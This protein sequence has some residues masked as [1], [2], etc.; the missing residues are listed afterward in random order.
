MG[1]SFN[2]ASLLNGNGISVSQIVQEL[3]SPQTSAINA[4]QNQQTDL[5]TNAGLLQGFNNNLTSLA[6]TVLDL[7]NPLGPLTAQSAS[8][9]DTGIL[10]ATALA[11]APAGSHR[12]VVS[13][14]AT[15]ATLY[16]DPVTNAGTSLLA[17]G[18]ITADITLQIGGASGTTHD[19]AISQGTNDTLTSLASFINSQQWGVTANVVTDANGSRLALYS[20]A[21]GAPGA[22]AIT[23]NTSVLSFNTPVGGTNASLTIDGVP[24]SSA[25]NAV[26][27]AISGVTLNLQSGDAQT[28]V[29]LTIGP[30]TDQATSAINSFVSAYN[31]LVNNLSSQFTL[32]PTSNTEGPLAADSFL[33]TLQSHLLNDVSYATGNSGLVNLASLGIDLNNDGTLTVN[34]TATET[35]P[36]LASVLASNPA[37]VQTFFQNATGDGFA[38]NFNNDLANLTDATQGILNVDLNGNK[39]QQTELTS[40][41]TALQDRLSAQQATLT[42][43]FDQVNATLEAYPSLLF[44]IT[45]EIGS[46]NG[47]YSATP[48]VLASTTP[49]S[50]TTASGSTNGS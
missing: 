28:T 46:I 38:Q 18:A 41:I 32:D 39:N 14:L 10:T 40:Q 30:D 29:Q 42:L 26:S 23:N 16:T 13:T 19:I 37:A 24:F 22:L 15:T 25:T 36:S 34:Q 27:G 17:N 1:I 20:Q 2:A 3:L 7:A 44:Q 12:I 9:S 8:S 43:Q 35:H 11:T 49:T 31:T 48:T 47:N 4:L 5:S 50:G 6:S 21:T 33:R 45:A